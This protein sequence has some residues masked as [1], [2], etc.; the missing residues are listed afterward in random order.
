MA[1]SASTQA[2]KELQQEPENDDFIDTNS[3]QT[4]ILAEHFE[5]LPSLNEVTEE[6]KYSGKCT[7]YMPT[8]LSSAAKLRPVSIREYHR[9]TNLRG[10]RVRVVAGAGAGCKIPTCDQPSPTAQ[11]GTT[12]RGLSFPLMIIM[13]VRSVHCRCPRSLKSPL[14]VTA[15]LLQLIVCQDFSDLSPRSMKFSCN[16]QSFSRHINKLCRV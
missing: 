3:E 13:S 8:M 1:E 15:V 14:Q 5:G 12:R 11:V 16:Q 10:S 9:L 7:H 6:L 2:K 4:K